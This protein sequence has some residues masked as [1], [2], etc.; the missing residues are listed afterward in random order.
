LVGADRRW[1]GPLLL[2]LLFL[3][4]QSAGGLTGA[5]KGRRQGNTSLDW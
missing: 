4:V 2:L 5:E 1:L 3:G